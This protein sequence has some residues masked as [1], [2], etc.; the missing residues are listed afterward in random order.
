MESW[1]AIPAMT[2][3]AN[4]SLFFK[5][6]IG[7]LLLS[8]PSSHSPS[9]SPFDKLRVRRFYK[10]TTNT[11]ELLNSNGSSETMLSWMS[12]SSSSDFIVVLFCLSK[13]NVLF[14]WRFL[15]R[16]KSLGNFL[17]KTIV[18]ITCA[19][20][21]DCHKA[22]MIGSHYLGLNGCKRNIDCSV[23]ISLQIVHWFQSPHQSMI[24]RMHGK[25]KQIGYTNILPASV[26]QNNK[27]QKVE[28]E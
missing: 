23:I 8:F 17:A 19:R 11:I 20:V 14:W 4:P 1:T 27:I 6:K 12:P 25:D 10:Q 3:S 13:K 18:L 2:L 26:Q 24:R 21:L 16:S 22:C 7:L 9:F 15:Q 28:G 5:Q